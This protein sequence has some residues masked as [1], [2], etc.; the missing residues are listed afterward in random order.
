MRIATNVEIAVRVGGVS[1]VNMAHHITYSGIG[2]L[3][4]ISFCAAWTSWNA[5][6][7]PKDPEKARKRIV[8]AACMMWGIAI[9]LFSAA[10]D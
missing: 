9:A 8:V 4:L 7:I 10:L 5:R 2:V 3:L 6:E 1:M